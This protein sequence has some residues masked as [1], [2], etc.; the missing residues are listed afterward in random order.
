[1]H[2]CSGNHYIYR[3]AQVNLGHCRKKLVRAHWSKRRN[4]Q[5][6]RDRIPISSS[7]RLLQDSMKMVSLIS[8]AVVRACRRSR[9]MG[10]CRVRCKEMEGTDHPTPFIMT[11]RI[12][13]HR[14]MRATLRQVRHLRHREH[15]DQGTCAST[16]T[17]Y[18]TSPSAF[19]PAPRCAGQPDGDFAHVSSD[20]MARSGR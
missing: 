16:N 5:R 20:P 19:V 4:V 7:I 13:I 18:P 14:S 3:H 1:M 10:S 8:T 17:C 9:M 2:A 15:A 6:L 12:G 11:G